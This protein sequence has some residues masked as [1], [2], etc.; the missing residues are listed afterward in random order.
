MHIESRFQEARDV[1]GKIMVDALSLQISDLCGTAAAD[2][3]LYPLVVPSQP[4]G[5]LSA[6]RVSARSQPA[7]VHLR[8]RREHIGGTGEI[9]DI[10]GL[11]CRSAEK[12]I[13]EKVS[14]IGRAVDK[15]I[16]PPL[17]LC[18]PAVQ[19]GQI[20]AKPALQRRTPKPPDIL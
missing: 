20:T 1:H 14:L 16:S 7:P 4:E 18:G 17:I 12:H 3:G 6:E 13:D 15:R 10:S 9:G 19:S 5:F 8:K 11:Q 2:N